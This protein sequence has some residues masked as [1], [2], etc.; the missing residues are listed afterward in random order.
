MKRLILTLLILLAS[1]YSYAFTVDT[2]L[3]NMITPKF[4]QFAPDPSAADQGSAD[5][6]VVTFYNIIDDQGVTPYY[7]NILHHDKSGT[8]TQYMVASDLDLSGYDR[9]RLYIENG[10]QFYVA[11]GVTLIL[12]PESNIEAFS[13]YVVGP[14]KVINYFP[15]N[16]GSIYYPDYK[17]LDQS[18]D[19]DDNSFADIKN[20]IGTDLATIY[21][22]NDDPDGETDF[23]FL[24]NFSIP[25][26]ITLE[27]E[28]GAILVPATSG[29]TI[30]PY[31]P[32]N[33][34]STPDQQIYDV[35]NGGA[36]VYQAGGKEHFDRFGANPADAISDHDAMSA[37]IS[38]LDGLG[39]EI[40]VLPGVYRHE[41]LT[42]VDDLTL[43]GLNRDASRL[44]NTH[45]SN[46]SITIT[47]LQ[48]VQIR[49]LRINSSGGSTGYGI[50]GY[51]SGSEVQRYPKI[52]NVRLLQHTNGII[53]EDP[54]DASIEQVY[55]SGKSRT[56]GIGIK[57]VLGTTVTVEDAYITQFETGVTTT[58]QGWIFDRMIIENFVTGVQSASRGI[59]REITLNDP[60]ASY[61]FDISNNGILLEG[62]ISSGSD[63]INYAD[64][65]ARRR[66][67]II[68]DTG[69]TPWQMFGR[70]VFY[71]SVIPTT[72][73]WNVGDTIYNQNADFPSGWACIE[74]GT[75]G[76]WR[77]IG[78]QLYYAK[79]ALSVSTGASTAEVDLAG[80]TIPANTLGA[81]PI[82]EGGGIKVTV[83]GKKTGGAG[84]KTIKLYFGATS[85]PVFP[86][87]NDAVEWKLEAIIQNTT[88]T[89]AQMVYWE[90][91]NN[92]TMTMN[93]TS[94]AIDTTAD[95]EVKVTGQH[96][97]AADR[98][99]VDY[100][101]V[102]RI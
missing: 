55:V 22:G 8:T 85:F 34:H 31:R 69:D 52:E 17:V 58:S 65:S 75:P 62:Y 63:R 29:V 23:T 102:E 47:G 49:D 78:Q 14:G 82:S 83:V 56:T 27:F 12:P 53:L 19:G 96:A 13:D 84:N 99:L 46:D 21:C 80:T 54:L 37:T 39:G 88:G 7:T 100:F 45:A 33:V 35:S 48:N 87:A 64:A 32:S 28:N 43:K 5:N 60:A 93:E 95:V 97:D 61:D 26:N 71:G 91:N 79:S 30:R 66:T 15:P 90:L 10:A 38:S 25:E 86:A 68:P 98:I 51:S 36:I 59:V 40:E 76:E 20:R 73:T 3:P 11:S 67:T 4:E 72:G 77:T 16:R 74:A 44:D 57:L 94:S 18:V 50:A 92:G 89:S 2:E 1:S 81:T 41:G 101:L 42:L 24:N 9:M 70:K 6:S